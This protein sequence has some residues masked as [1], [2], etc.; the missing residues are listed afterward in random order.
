LP[1][2]QL[3]ITGQVGEVTVSLSMTVFPTGVVGTGEIGEENVWGI[4]IPSQD[5]SWSAISI[6]QNPSWSS[7]TPSQDPSWTKIAA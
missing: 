5:P 4:I 1:P 7:T 6:T 2:T 3:P